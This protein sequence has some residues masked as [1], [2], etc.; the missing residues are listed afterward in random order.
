[1]RY[2]LYV[3]QGGRAISFQER[4]EFVI[5]RYEG[6]LR[7]F[8]DGDP[9]NVVHA[10]FPYATGS[11]SMQIKFQFR[12]YSA[13]IDEEVERL[14]QI[15]SAL[16]WFDVERVSVQ[17][18]KIRYRFVKGDGTRVKVD[19]KDLLVIDT[20]YGGIELKKGGALYKEE[21]SRV[22]TIVLGSLY[23]F[24]DDEVFGTMQLVAAL[25]RV[26]MVFSRQIGGI[27]MYYCAER[28]SYGDCSDYPRK[29][30]TVVSFDTSNAA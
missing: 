18:N 20:L 26:E 19:V 27:V 25:A 7:F 5:D 15:I 12:D 2:D 30:G 4:D 23:S 11:S 16:T 10:G 6:K 22:Q 29:N 14:A 21:S 1:M 28:I 13:M 9:M 17:E 24:L 8:R 3:R